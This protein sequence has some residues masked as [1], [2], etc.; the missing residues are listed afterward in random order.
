VAAVTTHGC[1]ARAVVALALVLPGPSFAEDVALVGGLIHPAPAAPP[2]ERGV[3]LVR[4][5]V[6]AAVGPR[7]ALAIPADARVLDCTGLTVTAGFWNS[8]VHL[9]SW[10]ML[11]GS[12]V[13]GALAANDLREMLTRWGFV[14]VVDT[15]SPLGT[16]VRLRERIRSGAFPGPEIRTTALGL[17]ARGGS[18]FY[19]KPFRV[20]E[21]AS[22]D[23]ARAAVAERLAEGADGIKL[24]TGGLAA[25][26][27]VVV[28]DVALVRAVTE[29]AHARGAFVV[30]HPTNSAGARAALEGGVDVLA[31]TF[32]NSRDGQWDRTIPGEMRQR[33]MALVPTLAVWR[34][35]LAREGLPEEAI[36]RFTR[37][38][39]DQVRSFAALGGQ[40]LFG[41]D[42]GYMQAFDPGDDYALLAEAGLSFAQIL[43]SLTTAP[44]ERFGAAARTGRLEPGLDADLVVL[45]G[46]PERDVRA[47]ARVRYAMRRGVLL[48]ASDGP[49]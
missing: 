40:I 25:P 41:T 29:A 42:V 45:D 21:L 39:E 10:R 2:I 35:D 48:Y 22:A 14:H 31:H 26:D 38:A 28:M 1:L 7:E 13:L 30:A 3:V 47:L 27:S 12:R 44:A 11:I 8:H 19:L 5:G 34:W 36:V 15:G 32:P 9:S 18:P 4:D 37:V 49:R 16:A 24:F 20:P 17:A 23:E 6:V 33:G 43:E 46:D